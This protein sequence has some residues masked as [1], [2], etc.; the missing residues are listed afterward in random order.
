MA[1]R[2]TPSPPPPA[3]VEV[4][5]QE[6]LDRLKLSP[7]VAW[8]LL[9][10]GHGL[11][12]E[13]QVPLWKT[14]E[15]GSL[16]GAVF[17]PARVD[18]VLRAFG[19]LRHT[20]GRWAGQPLTPAVWQV[21]YILAPTFGWLRWDGECDDWVRVVRGAVV[22]VSR[23][24]GKTTIAGGTAMYLTAADGEP[25]AQVLTVA[26]SK[27]Q[28]R[29]CFAPVKMLAERSPD[30]APYVRALADRIVH[31]AS[32]SYLAVCASVGDLLHGANVH[33]AVVDELHV[34]KTS[35]V[36]D[37]VETGTG[38]RSQPLILI[39][40][41][42]DEGKPGTIYARKRLRLEQ[43]ARG[44]IVDPTT[45]GV[46][47]AAAESEADLKERGLDPFG[48]TALRRANPGYGVSPTKAFLATA[49][50][51]AKDSPLELARYLRLHL[52]IRTKQATRYIRLEDWDA[53]DN[54]API[55][56]ASLAG[57]PC[58]GG[59]DLAS[60]SDLTALCWIF[61]DRSA[62][63]YRAIWRFWLP[64]KALDDLDRRTA[65]N[66]AVW[67]RE[68]WIQTTPGRV[69]DTSSVNERLDQDAQTFQVLTVGYDRWGAND[70][71]KKASDAGMT[72]VPIAQGFGS[73]SA[74][75]KE[76]KRLTLTERFLHG[77]NPVARWCLDNLAVAVDRN[78]NVR[79]DKETA[80]DK[81]D[82]VVAAID[83]M[84]ECMDAEA[85]EVVNAPVAGPSIRP[86]SGDFFRPSKRLAI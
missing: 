51:T 27:E 17:D 11:P 54:S 60:V 43:L 82:G 24:N 63:L 81:I 67:A 2:A 40:S 48:E 59:L 5:D 28:A 34:H 22:D 1:R 9:D 84:K 83:A 21:A 76:I 26:A 44:A 73:L 8:Y 50:A 20:Q 86:D 4:P 79:P 39:I 37:A 56:E 78:G 45:Y 65:G 14:P 25:G 15:G 72:L 13:W 16:E 74:P 70:V 10:R 71:T 38:A 31:P 32:G 47:F 12:E 53:A 52:G 33:G 36:V 68:G 46:V 55:D 58:H 30:L 42:A 61:P 49:A 64:E 7:E 29:F 3:D 23:K 85:A 19:R 77:G 62:D 80:G 57:L 66:A 35:D 41:T 6:T 18:K 69:L 75:L